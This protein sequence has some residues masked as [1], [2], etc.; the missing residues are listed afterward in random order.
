MQQ[1]W[2]ALVSLLWVHNWWKIMICIIL[3]LIFF[4]HGIHFRRSPKLTCTE[5][6]SRLYER[7]LL[8]FQPYVIETH[9]YRKMTQSTHINWETLLYWFVRCFLKGPLSESES[10]RRIRIF[11]LVFETMLW[12]YELLNID[13]QHGTKLVREPQFT[14]LLLQLRVAR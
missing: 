13:R 10:G 7:I 8:K 9:I 1:A 12:S 14:W 11:R 5:H 6:I 2:R 3:T 4:L